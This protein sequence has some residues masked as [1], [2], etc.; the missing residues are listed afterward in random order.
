MPLLA[1][2]SR[3]ATG[4][5]EINWPPLSRL[6]SAALQPP[7]AYEL[8]QAH[9]SAGQKDGNDD[10]DHTVEYGI[11]S[12]RIAAKLRIPPLGQRDQ[13]QP[14]DLPGPT[15]AAPPTIAAKA[16]FTET[17]MPKVLAGSMNS[18]YWA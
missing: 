15:T 3:I 14:L 6:S 7:C 2:G 12:V 10:Q 13:E 9:Q 11:D 4:Q 5:P 17:N 16:I 8:W 18:R 1:L